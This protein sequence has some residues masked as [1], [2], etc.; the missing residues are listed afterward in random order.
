MSVGGHFC[1]DGDPYDLAIDMMVLLGLDRVFR[2]SNVCQSYDVRRGIC[3]RRYAQ[4]HAVEHWVAKHGDLEIAYHSDLIRDQVEP[5]IYT[6]TTQ[7]PISISSKSQIQL[8][9]VK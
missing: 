1:H 9:V 7:R 5:G 4:F 6:E 8:W 2:G 3:K